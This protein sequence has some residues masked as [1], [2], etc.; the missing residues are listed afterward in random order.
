MTAPL[1]ESLVDFC[2]RLRGWGI[3][4]RGRYPLVGGAHGYI[5]M[6][7]LGPLHWHKGKEGLMWFPDRLSK[8]FLPLACSHREAT[9]NMVLRSFC[10]IKLTFPTRCNPFLLLTRRL[11]HLVVVGILLFFFNHSKQAPH[12]VPFQVRCFGGVSIEWEAQT[13]CTPGTKLSCYMTW[14]D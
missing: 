3:G 14:K 2:G 12:P 11:L 7:G 1:C 9:L 5:K 6:T 4:S 10:S 8:V 13:K